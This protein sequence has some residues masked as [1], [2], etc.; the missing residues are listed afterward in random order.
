MQ[1][2]AG[3]CWK[4]PEPAGQKAE[5]RGGQPDICPIR[6]YSRTCARVDDRGG[7]KRATRGVKEISRE[8][9]SPFLS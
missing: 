5:K 9:A 6:V 4:S 8:V 3:F 1:S 2:A 7:S